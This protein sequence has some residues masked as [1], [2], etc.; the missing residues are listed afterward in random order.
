MTWSFSGPANTPVM[1]CAIRLN[2]TSDTAVAATFTALKRA[3]SPE[4]RRSRGPTGASATQPGR[5]LQRLPPGTIIAV[6]LH[7]VGQAL[8]EG[9]LRLVAQFLEDLGA[10]HG[11]ALV[12]TE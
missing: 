12:M 4:N 9:D 7:C 6:P 5:S 11:V 8:L 1:P 10:V 3:I 2:S